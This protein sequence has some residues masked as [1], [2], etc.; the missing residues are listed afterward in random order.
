VPP[1]PETNTYEGLHARYYDIVYGE[2]PYAAEARYVT[3]LLEDALPSEKRRTLL[4]LACGTGRHATEFASLGYSVTGVDFNPT[5]VERAR[6]NAT[7]RGVDVH[8]LER[9]IRRLELGDERFD[10]ITCLF[11]SIG[12]L[13]TN[14]RLLEAFGSAREHLAPDGALVLEFLH[15]PAMIKHAAPVRIRRWPTP[16]GGMLLRISESS[17]NLA[18]GALHVAYELLELHDDTET[19]SRSTETQAN[20]FFSLE[21]M[22]A[23]LTAAGFTVDKFLSAY[24]DRDQIDDETWHVLAVARPATP[25]REA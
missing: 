8:F 6:V 2:K 19:Y 11:D 1:Q 18:A 20:R 16:D 22:R 7:E 25:D 5:L 4:D 9:D 21:E 10:A 13:L 3:E 15:A 24:D 14:E 12:Y 23:L 17:L